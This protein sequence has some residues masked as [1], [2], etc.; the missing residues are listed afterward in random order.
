MQNLDSFFNSIVSLAD[1]L[2]RIL[3]PVPKIF[4]S[5]CRKLNVQHIFYWLNV[6][7]LCN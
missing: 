6:F 7:I 5:Y 2:N 4:V 1:V 3:W